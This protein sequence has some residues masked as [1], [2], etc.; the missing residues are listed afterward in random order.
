MRSTIIIAAALVA[1][2]S[3]ANAATYGGQ[4]KAVPAT[5]TARLT[6]VCQSPSLVLTTS[7]KTACT[8]GSF[9]RVTAAATAFI[10][11]GTGAEL[12]TLMRQLPAAPAVASK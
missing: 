11:S 4:S 12:N 6:A 5:F 2:T 9:P 7:A 10:N 1:L 3:G 8:T